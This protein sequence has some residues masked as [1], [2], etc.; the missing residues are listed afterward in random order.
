MRFQVIIL[1][2]FN[3]FTNAQNLVPN[4][5]F[6]SIK[7]TIGGFTNENYHFDKKIKDWSAINTASPDI[8]TPDFSEIYI[9]VSEPHSGSNMAGLQ[10]SMD[11]W[12]K[13]NHSGEYVGI[14]LISDLIPGRTYYIEYWIRRA[15]CINPKLN[16]DHLLHDNFGIFFYLDTILHSGYKMLEVNPQ[17]KGE[18]E[19]LITDKEW[20][21]VS[22]YFT[23]VTRCN[24][25]IIGQFWKNETNP[26]IMKGYY[27]IDD[28]LVKEVKDFGTIDKQ[29]GLSV[30]TIIPLNQINFVFG[31]TKLSD[32]K[33][34]I[35]LN[36]LIYYLQSNIKIKVKVNGHTDNVGSKE[37][38][39]NLSK[40]RAKFIAKFIIKSGIKKDRIE[41]E[42]FAD[43]KPIADNKSEDG[44]SQNRR[45]EFEIIP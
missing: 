19:V 31:T 21:K 7:D 24:K 37:S 29:I 41:W 27:Q 22:N 5:S 39:F 40:E 2:F 15:L 20:V 42:G 9:K 36:E 13:E 30:G 43:A 1:F 25:L 6:E 33:S 4:S 38:N 44:R 14:K 17:V 34:F 18:K 3:T 8:I 10:S 26:S 16:F 28:I 23:P 32:Q 12:D 11:Y 45:V 35:Q